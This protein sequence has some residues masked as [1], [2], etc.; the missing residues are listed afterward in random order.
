LPSEIME[1]VLTTRSEKE[2]GFRDLKIE[3]Q[4][5]QQ[6]SRNLMCPRTPK[7]CNEIPAILLVFQYIMYLRFS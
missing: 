6:R 4:R 3:R 7:F 1:L 2:Q 5:D